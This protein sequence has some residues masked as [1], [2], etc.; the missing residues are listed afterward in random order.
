MGSLR[1]LELMRKETGP[2]EAVLHGKIWWSVVGQAGIRERNFSIRLSRYSGMR[3]QSS[4]RDWTSLEERKFRER[5]NVSLWCYSAAWWGVPGS[6]FW[7][8]SAIWGLLYPQSLSYLWYVRCWMQFW[9]VC[10]V[11]SPQWLKYVN[12]DYILKSLIR[13]NLNLAQVSFGLT[14]LAAV[15][16]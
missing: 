4:E 14:V 8:A 16:K 3:T 10:K 9:R 13:T 6:E 5:A 2:S 7:Q 12:L 1:I 11:N 15:K